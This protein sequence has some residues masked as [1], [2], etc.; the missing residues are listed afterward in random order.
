MIEKFIERENQNALYLLS[1]VSM[2][3][4][5]LVVA[6]QPL[7]LRNVLEISFEKAGLINA[8]IQVV[9]ELLDLVLILFLGYLSD[10]YGRVPIATMGLLVAAAGALLAPFSLQ[11]GTLL[12]IGGLGFYYL[13]RVVM[14]LGSGAVWPQISALAGDFTS[15]DNRPRIMANTVF[16]MAL[17]ATLVYAV[18]MQIPRHAGFITVMLMTA[19]VALIGAVVAHRCLSDVAPKLEQGRVPWRQ[20]RDLLVKEERLRLGFVSAF[21]ARSDMVFIGMFLMMWFIYF[22]DIVGVGQAEAAAR[23]GALI[24]YAGVVVLVSVSFWGR[25]IENF[26]R[27]QS[28][29][30]GLVLSGLGFAS[31]GFVVNP[32]DWF[33]VL[34]MTLI[35]VGQAGCLIAPQVLTIDMTP[36]NIRGSVLGAFNVVGGIGIIFFVQTGGFLFDEIGPHAPFVFIG[37][38]NLLLVCYAAWVM[39]GEI[40][41]HRVAEQELNELE[42]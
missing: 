36:E 40:G 8:N 19:A 18:L 6:I 9:T 11:L 28:L 5:T 15:Y 3:F 39:R 7:F 13:M 35:A 24:G 33:I 21:F 30:A 22:A 31:M 25:L 14:S 32:F 34:P 1:A 29:A 42:A 2:V 20:V 38:G 26:G 16:M 10:R 4:M 12:G 37:F 41:G 27:V 23:G 17:G